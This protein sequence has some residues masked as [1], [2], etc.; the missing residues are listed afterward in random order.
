MIVFFHFYWVH[1]LSRFGF[2][3]PGRCFWSTLPRNSEQSFPVIWVVQVYL[4]F[5][6]F[7][8]WRYSFR[9][10]QWWS[11]S[12]FHLLLNF[13]SFFGFNLLRTSSCWT[14][15]FF[16][17]CH[18]FAW[19][20]F[21]YRCRTLS[22]WWI[23]SIGIWLTHKVPNCTQNTY[24]NQHHWP[25]SWTFWLLCRLSS[26]LLKINGN[27]ALLLLQLPYSFLFQ[28]ISSDLFF[29]FF[30]PIGIRIKALFSLLLKLFFQSFTF[31]HLLFV[32]P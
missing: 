31:E 5:I 28:F 15:F 2:V 4:L 27:L 16:G 22:R 25:T 6:L 24:S 10:W 17:S 3:H 19:I 1:F 13:W 21:A 30:S 9:S 11:R 29:L 23:W 32:I 7:F 26:N 14:I 8:G 20:T 18:F 12:S